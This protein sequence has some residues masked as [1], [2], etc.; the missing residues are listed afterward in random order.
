MRPASTPSFSVSQAGRMNGCGRV[1]L[2][3]KFLH[4]HMCMRAGAD[5]H[6]NIV[7]REFALPATL[8]AGEL[9]RHRDAVAQIALVDRNQAPRLF[10]RPIRPSPAGQQPG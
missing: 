2:G 9:G 7:G 6:L 4:M 3:A 10:D 5:E 8:A 1:M